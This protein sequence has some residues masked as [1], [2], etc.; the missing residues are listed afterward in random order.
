MQPSATLTG[1]FSIIEKF[2]PG[3]AIDGVVWSEDSSYYAYSYI[4]GNKHVVQACSLQHLDDSCRTIISHFNNWEHY[5]LLGLQG[6]ASK[7]RIRSLGRLPLTL[8][9]C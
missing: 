5:Y 9:F 3:N 6:A 2:S 1:H 4:A 8:F 7:G